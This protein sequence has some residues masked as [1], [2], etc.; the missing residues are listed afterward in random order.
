MENL[1][2]QKSSNNTATISDVRTIMGV[3]N[4][5]RLIQGWTMLPPSDAEPIAKVWF[6]QLK[7]NKMETSNLP[8]LLNEAVSYRV[9]CIAS[10]QTPPPLTIETLIAME[11]RNQTKSSLS[12]EEIDGR[13]AVRASMEA[14]NGR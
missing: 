9:K 3:I 1:E 6:E 10:G 4:S 11:R 13:A 5:A 2:M 12:Q 8:D 7:A 14:W